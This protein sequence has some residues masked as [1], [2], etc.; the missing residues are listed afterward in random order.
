MTSEA[1]VHF[2]EARKF[3]DSK[4]SDPE[5]RNLYNGLQKLTV[6]IEDLLKKVETL[7]NEIETLKHRIP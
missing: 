2:I 7:E 3:L 4:E 5:K 1:L 6:M